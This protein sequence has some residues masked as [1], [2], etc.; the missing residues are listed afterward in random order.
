MCTTS[1]HP[2]QL[3]MCS[4]I[5]HG[6]VKLDNVIVCI[7]KDKHTV[8]QVCNISICR[9]LDYKVN[10]FPLYFPCTY[11][12]CTCTLSQS[13]DLTQIFKV[14]NYFHHA[15]SIFITLVT[16]RNCQSFIISCK[17]PPLILTKTQPIYLWCSSDP[18]YR[19]LNRSI[20][21]LFD[22][23]FLHFQPRTVAIEN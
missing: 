4:V 23:N 13:W 21:W 5:T 15:F 6:A 20:L 10:L 17:F 12:L 19:E 18:F 2:D 16:A 22:L 3:R 11:I 8:N 7:L 14:V 1:P 9:M